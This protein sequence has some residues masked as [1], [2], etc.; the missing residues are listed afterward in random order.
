MR[1]K[2]AYEVEVDK[3][4]PA[5]LRVELSSDIFADKMGVRKIF[6]AALPLT[7]ISHQRELPR[8]RVRILMRH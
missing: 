6:K 2:T 8:R 3:N 1:L 4:V 7:G 5:P